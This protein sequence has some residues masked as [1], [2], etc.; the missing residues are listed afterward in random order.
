MIILF[1]FYTKNEKV[2]TSKENLET[3]TELQKATQK[4][5]NNSSY[6][7]HFTVQIDAGEKEFCGFIDLEK[8]NTMTI[9]YWV[10]E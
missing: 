4:V 1:L 10:Y 2:E 5:D 9:G 3:E 7:Q 6:T 8:G